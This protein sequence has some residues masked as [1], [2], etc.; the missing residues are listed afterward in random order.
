MMLE[1]KIVRRVEATPIASSLI[2]GLR[3]IGYS[4]ETAISDVIDNSITAKAK[5]I[6]I[7]TDTFS[8]E[9]FIAIVDDGTGMTEAELIAAMRP[10]S[11]N[12][13]ASRDEP[14]LGRFGLGMKTA[15]FSQ[16]RRLTVVSRK[17][18]LTSVAVWDLDDVAKHNAWQVELPDSAEGIPGVSHLGATGTVVL[19]QKLD[20]LTGGHSHSAEKRAEVINRR[21]AETESHL[22]LVFHRFLEDPKP[23]RLFLNNRMLRPIDP[24]ARKN[25]AT[26]HGDP[27][28]IHLVRGDVEFQTFTIPHNKQMSKTDWEEIGGPEGHLKSQGFYLYRAK[29]LILHGTWFGLSR[30]SELTKLS[31]VRVDIPNSIDADWKIDVKKS[32]AQ[33]PNQVR[34]RMK[35][36]IE[37]I[38]GGSKR[39]YQKRGARLV[40]QNRLP[41][42]HR[43]Q[44]DGQISYSPNADHPALTD[45]AESLPPDLRKGFYNC[46][47]LMGASLPLETLHADMAGVPEQIVAHK[48]DAESLTQAVQ[49]T[50]TQLLAAKYPVKEIKA[51]MRE[52]DP[53]RSSWEETQAIID[54]TLDGEAK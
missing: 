4:L 19:W 22:R 16:C 38:Q 30:Q 29:R 53:F 17:N 21:L 36:L 51:L 47:A 50:L 42:W 9:P 20:R 11:R 44:S 23:L 32:S 45:F 26:I 35:T 46:I 25:P 28:T 14:D 13:L 24:F 43:L 39:T 15:S 8:D 48:L 33:L 27:S 2:E 1:K 18:G 54:A 52:V 10:G 3:D 12:P 40:D 41:L 31:R 49:A 34:A 6:D 7:V 37:T 5:R